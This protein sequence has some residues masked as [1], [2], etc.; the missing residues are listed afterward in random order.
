MASKAA[1]APV[2]LSEN[3]EAAFPVAEVMK[4][5]LIAFAEPADAPP[6]VAGLAPVAEPVEPLE[7]GVVDAVFFELL[8]HAE[9]TSASRPAPIIAAFIPR[10]L[11]RF[12][13]IQTPPGTGAT[14]SIWRAISTPL[15]TRKSGAQ[16]S[17]RRS[18]VS[19]YAR[20]MRLA[21]A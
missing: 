7:E 2:A 15:L 21:V 5:T 14:R 1:L 19:I 20:N 16:P 8:P 18:G 12:P 10:D 4:P 17:A 9:A 6:V 3:V 11:K 13:F